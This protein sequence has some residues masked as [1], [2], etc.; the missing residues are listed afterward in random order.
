MRFEF[1]VEPV[2]LRGDAAGRVTAI[3]FRR[4]RSGGDGSGVGAASGFEHEHPAE[5]V[6][7]A[8][9]YSAAPFRGVGDSGDLAVDADGRIV[10]DAALMSKVPGVF[11]GGSLIRGRVPA[12][13]TV[14]DARAAARSIDAY[15]SRP[16][17]VGAGQV[18]P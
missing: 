1:Q 12:V 14:R 9:G 3:L 17:S 18:G 2:A 13:E 8:L 6:F 4:N 16:R 15:L 5:V 11:A 7:G 10:V